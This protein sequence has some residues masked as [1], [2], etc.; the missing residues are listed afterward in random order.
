MSKKE[1]V[2]TSIDS[3]I[4]AIDA[5]CTEFEVKDFQKGVQLEVTATLY[6]ERELLKKLLRTAVGHLQQLDGLYMSDEVPAILKDLKEGKIPDKIDD[7]FSKVNLKAE[8]QDIND[9][10]RTLESPD[11]EL[12]TIAEQGFQ[13]TNLSTREIINNNQII[14][15][16]GKIKSAGFSKNG[17]AIVIEDAIYNGHDF[18]EMAKVSMSEEA[19]RIIFIKQ[20]GELGF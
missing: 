9:K 19:M 6:K 5:V 20:Q 18:E 8:I 17:K 12:V 16:G 10:L 4:Q 13:V 11:A 2:I 1:P 3:R 7:H 15:T 14:A